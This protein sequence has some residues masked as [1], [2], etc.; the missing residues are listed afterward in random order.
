MNPSSPGKHIANSANVEVHVGSDCR[1][2]KPSFSSH[3]AYVNHLFSGQ[4]FLLAWV[5][6]ILDS[7]LHVLA[8][9]S[10]SQVGW[11]AACPTG[12]AVMEDNK[13]IRNGGAET[14]Y[15]R[16]T[17]GVHRS[18]W[19]FPASQ[20]CGSISIGLDISLPRPAFINCADFNM[21]PKSFLKRYG[22]KLRKNFLG[23]R[24]GVHSVSRL[25]VCRA[26]GC[27]NNAR[28]FAL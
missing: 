18:I 2:A 28:A 10:Q 16:N 20:G 3:V 19:A 22:N 13:P 12:A 23:N 8:L 15:P 27:S 7:V 9:R 26:L 4:S 17:V 11:I 1:I 21:G 5:R 14:Y 24:L 25:I 6:A